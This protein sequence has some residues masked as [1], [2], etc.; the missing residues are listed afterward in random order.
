MDLGAS[1]SIETPDG[2]AISSGTKT[3]LGFFLEPSNLPV[4]GPYAVGLDPG[5]LS[6][7]SVTVT[8][9]DVPDDVSGSITTGGSGVQVAITAPGQNAVLK[10]D[11]TAGQR[12]SLRRTNGLNGTVSILRPDGSTRSRPSPAAPPTRSS[13][14]RC[15]TRPG[16]TPSSLNPAGASTGRATITLYAVPD[17]LA[18]TLTIKD[19]R[20][21]SRCPRPARTPRPRS[22]EARATGHHHEPAEPHDHVGVRPRRSDR[23]DD[24]AGHMQS[25][26]LDAAGRPVSVTEARGEVSLFEHNAHDEV[27]DDQRPAGRRDGVHVRWQRQPA[28]AD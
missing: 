2:T 11:A 14:R 3:V 20:R 7:G 22:A 1:I 15:S 26:L 21:R 13:T 6:T 8:V 18:G 5:G 25:R 12:V 27:H 9:Y 10:F 28:H 16:A 23:L 4:S 19:P 17:D 24:S